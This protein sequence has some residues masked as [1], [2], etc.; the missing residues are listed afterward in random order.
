MAL[1][2][3]RPIPISLYFCLLSKIVVGLIEDLPGWRASLLCQIRLSA[4][5]PE[6]PR[7]SSISSGPRVPIAKDANTLV[8]RLGWM[9]GSYVGR[10]GTKMAFLRSVCLNTEL[11]QYLGMFT[12]LPT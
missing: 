3:N 12:A 5:K 7:R 6:A 2:V 9:A 10:L 11:L 1:H 4:W 8:P